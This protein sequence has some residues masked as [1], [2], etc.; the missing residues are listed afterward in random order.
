MKTVWKY[1]LKPE[2]ALEI[3]KE[4]WILQVEA[5]G[6]N[7][8]LW[9]MVDTE[10]EKE[11][12]YFLIVGTGHEIKHHSIANIGSVMLDGGNLVFHVFESMKPLETRSY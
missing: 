2:C 5:Q 6:N 8:C 1:I 7:I 3:P 12:R 9:V 4:S 11:T 10:K